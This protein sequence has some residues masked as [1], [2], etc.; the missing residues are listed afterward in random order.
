MKQEKLFTKILIII[1]LASLNGYSQTYKVV[2]T[3]QTIFYN[4]LSEINSPGIGD[5]Y[6]GQDA[7]YDGYQPSYTDNGDGTIT[8]NVTGLM[9]SKTPDMNGDSEINAD[10]KL[11]Y[12]NA[13]AGAASFNLAGYN[14]WRLPTIKEQYSLG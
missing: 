4:N 1:L 9:W 12:T 13:L 14:D 3:G 10:D 2:D 5:D 7:Q 6:Y 8:D 11:S